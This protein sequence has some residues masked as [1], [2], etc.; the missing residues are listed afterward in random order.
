M[1]KLITEPTHYSS[2]SSDLTDFVTRI[3]IM[4]EI[5][6][7]KRRNPL[8]FYTFRDFRQFY[9]ANFSVDLYG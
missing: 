2:Q 9:H 4:S 1:K 8:E 5:N 6:C 7:E 3:I